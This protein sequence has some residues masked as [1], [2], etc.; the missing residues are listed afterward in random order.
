MV[1]SV[2]EIVG[3]EP[4]A[5]DTVE[6]LVWSTGSIHLDLSADY[7]QSTISSLGNLYLKGNVVTHD[8]LLSSLGNLYSFALV[9]MILVLFRQ[10][11]PR[12]FTQNQPEKK[13]I[14]HLHI[15]KHFYRILHVFALPVSGVLNLHKRIHE[16]DENLCR[17]TYNISP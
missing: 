13:L 3:T 9:I 14:Q 10:L 16:E 6:L 1:A 11:L 5:V 17:N 15:Y 7:L 8:A 4:F 2:G 12:L